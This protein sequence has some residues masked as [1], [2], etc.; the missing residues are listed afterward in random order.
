MN[1][2]TEFGF[3]QTP[4]CVI[5]DGP[6]ETDGEGGYQYV[7]GFGDEDGEFIDTNKKAIWILWDYDEVVAFAEKLAAKYKLELVFEASPA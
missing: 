2:K 4:A 3:E 1:A 5:A 6:Q 7:V